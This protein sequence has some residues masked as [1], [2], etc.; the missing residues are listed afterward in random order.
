MDIR[1][2][3][4]DCK[5]NE[6]LVCKSDKTKIEPNLNCSIYKKDIAKQTDIS[7]NIFEGD[8]KIAPYKHNKKLCLECDADCLFNKN[9]NCIANGITINDVEDNPLCIT[10]MKK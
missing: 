8:Y 9:K 10:Y 1:C 2:R 7:K 5:Y 6:G 3:K 4:T